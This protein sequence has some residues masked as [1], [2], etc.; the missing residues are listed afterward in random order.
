MA[1]AEDTG[2]TRPDPSD[3]ELTF[4]GHE[5]FASPEPKTHSEGSPPLPRADVPS[6]ASRRRS[7]IGR[8][9]RGGV[10]Q[11]TDAPR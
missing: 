8:L 1:A 5:L 6:S 3:D 7:W 11:A 2:P 4:R 9:I 10:D